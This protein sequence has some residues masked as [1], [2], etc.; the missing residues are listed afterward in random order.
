MV[1]N[2]FIIGLGGVGGRSI[3]AFRRAQVVL[4]DDMKHLEKPIDE[5]GMD[6]RFAYLYI[7]SND[8]IWDNNKIWAK[9]GSNQKL[10]QTDFINLKSDRTSSRFEDL[11]EE[12]NIRPWI[13]QMAQNYS[14]K[15]QQGSN[16][17]DALIGMNGAG[18]LR[19]YGRVL[20]ALNANKI[21]QQLR[22]KIEKLHPEDIDFHI[23][24]TLGGG[25]GSGSIVDMVTLIQYLAK[26]KGA[27]FSTYIYP[28]IASVFADKANTGN[29]FENE[30]A[31]L[32]DLNA[33]MVGRYSP[34][35]AGVV[36]NIY[37]D[38]RYRYESE[39]RP[40]QAIYISSDRS[41]RAELDDQIEFIARGCLDCII[42]RANQTDNAMLKPFT[43]EDLSDKVGEPGGTSP[44]R[45]YKLRI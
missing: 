32:R 33:L 44:E 37:G 3:A 6:F 9:Y 42:L 19:R 15:S 8:D 23:F 2:H 22:T 30:Y 34:Y 14:K 10:S 31:A 5:G 40:I 36:N 4:S 21:E 26:Q 16:S 7:D 20:F 25:T 39:R 38:D 1:K 43:F 41:N 45:G 28:F 27:K 35:M 29:M 12:T 24:C 17:T 18:Q 11:I 13:G